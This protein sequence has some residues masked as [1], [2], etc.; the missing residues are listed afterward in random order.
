M[1]LKANYV[2]IFMKIKYGKAFI[3]RGGGTGPMKPSNR[4]LGPVLIP[5]G[6]ISF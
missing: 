2:T 3:Q 1:T 5:A 6:G 4:P